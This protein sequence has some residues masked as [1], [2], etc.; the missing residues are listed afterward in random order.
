MPS[1]RVRPLLVPVLLL[2]A[3]GL[4]GCQSDTAS[5]PTLPGSAQSAAA[6]LP[7][8]VPSHPFKVDRYHGPATLAGLKANGSISHDQGDGWKQWRYRDAHTLMKVTLYG[9]PGGWHQMTAKE[10]VS[11]HYGQLRQRKVNAI[12]NSA[13]RSLKFVNER[14]F[15]LDGHETVISQMLINAPDQ[16]PLYEVLLLTLDNNH[17][18][19]LNLLSDQPNTKRLATMAKIALT[20]FRKA[21]KE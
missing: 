14:E 15:N 16:N 6:A 19:R 10:I 21:N 12:Y 20:E 9:L 17:F 18:V 8:D 4:A 3:T 2:A 11:G 7:H 13:N 1:S 5:L